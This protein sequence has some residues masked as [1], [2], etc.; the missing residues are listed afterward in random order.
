[1][2]ELTLKAKTA[3][4]SDVLSVEGLEL[5]TLTQYDIPALASLYTA[6]YGLYP[7]AE[8]LWQSTDEVRLYF[9]GALGTPRDDSFIGAW[10]DGELVGAIICVLDSPF[11]GVPRGPFVLDLMVLPEFRRRGIAQALVHELATRTG[12]WGYDSLTLRLDMRQMP[13]AFS[14][15]QRMGFSPITEEINE[16]R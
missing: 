8:N 6:A 9:D 12:R 10:F 11:D 5:A 14:L 16:S 1:M 13:E 15:Y 7:T 3:S 4:V 2:A